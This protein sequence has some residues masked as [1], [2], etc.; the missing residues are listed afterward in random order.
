MLNGVRLSPF[1]MRSVNNEPLLFG[2]RVVTNAS[3]YGPRTS[4][5]GLPAL[6]SSNIHRPVVLA[7]TLQ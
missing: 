1:L 6:V 7:D 3:Q 5:L 4:K 2:K